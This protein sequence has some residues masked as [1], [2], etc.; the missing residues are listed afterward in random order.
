VCEDFQR[1]GFPNVIL[2]PNVQVAYRD[3]HTNY[4]YNFRYLKMLWKKWLDSLDK[5]A[6]PAVF[7]RNDAIRDM[8][9]STILVR[10][11]LKLLGCSTR[12]LLACVR[13]QEGAIFRSLL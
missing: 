6:D 7:I 4:L 5:P 9:Q 13:L 2:D 1:L 10:N 11:D 12:M 8:T 3:D